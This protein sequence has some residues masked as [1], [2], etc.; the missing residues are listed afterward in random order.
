MQAKL[1]QNTAFDEGVQGLVDG[2]QG[3]T[4]YL[5]ANDCIDLLRTG[6][7][8]SRHQRL[9]YNSALMSQGQTVPAAQFAKVRVL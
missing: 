5:L 7:A 4:G 3:D 9:V 1:A 2:S 6:M 8:R